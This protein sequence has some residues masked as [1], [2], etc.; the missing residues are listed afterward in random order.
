MNSIGIKETVAD[1]WDR[2]R[3]LFLESLEI[4]VRIPENWVLIIT[5]VFK[6]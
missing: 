1:K 4:D 3:S 5:R 2:A 6:A